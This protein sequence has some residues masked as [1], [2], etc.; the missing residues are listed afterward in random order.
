MIGQ[1][2]KQVRPREAQGWSSRDLHVHAAI[3]VTA[4]SVREWWLLGRVET[5]DGK[6]AKNIDVVCLRSRM[7]RYSGTCRSRATR[8][9]L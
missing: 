3:V 9:L 4:A 7:W 5:S 6:V 2:N 8:G 1:V